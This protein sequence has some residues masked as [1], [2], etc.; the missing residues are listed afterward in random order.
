M[1]TIPGIDSFSTTI[2]KDRS[3]LGV[4][5]LEFQEVALQGIQW[6]VLVCANGGGQRLLQVLCLKLDISG[7]RD[8]N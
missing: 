6:V 5:S 8:L 7:K 4:D 2:P 3:C 1:H